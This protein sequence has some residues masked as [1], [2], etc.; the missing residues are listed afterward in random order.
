MSLFY[1]LEYVRRYHDVVVYFISD[2]PAVEYYRKH[3]IRCVVEPALSKFPHC[4]IDYECLNPFAKKFYRDLRIY[5]K[6]WARLIS[7]YRVMRRIIRQED[8]RLVHLNSSVLLAEGIAAR[9][10]GRPLIWHIR[11]FL[12]RGRPGV[13]GA[14]IASVIRHAATRIVALCPSEAARLGNSE[15]VTVIPNFVRLDQFNPSRAESLALRK[16][17]GLPRNAA[18][19]GMLGWSIP[20]KGALVAV[21][22][23]RYVLEQVPGAVLLLYGGGREAAEQGGLRGLAKRVLL[24]DADVY[25]AVQ[26]RVHAI[27]LQG[28]VIFPGTV[29]NVADYIAELDVVIAPFTVPHFARPILEAGAMRKPVVTSDLDGTREMVLYGEA[30]Y[31]A[32]PGDARDLAGRIVEAVRSDNSHKLNRMYKNVMENYNADVNAART[33]ALYEQFCS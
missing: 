25:A 5:P 29:F 4:T 18:L 15:K 11:D 13:R 22:A 8:P 26:R 16:G 28:K 31:L 32:R 2:G 10:E 7:T 3:G 23:M 30:G 27:G 17:L 33:M 19:V 1:L 6:Y 21:E 20:G 14:L 24:G 12:V 9:A